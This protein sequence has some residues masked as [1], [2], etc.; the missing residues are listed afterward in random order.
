MKKFYSHN[1]S[2]NVILGSKTWWYICT[3]YNDKKKESYLIAEYTHTIFKDG[4][5]ETKR[6]I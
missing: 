4:S 6:V 2:A 5:S 3:G 1:R